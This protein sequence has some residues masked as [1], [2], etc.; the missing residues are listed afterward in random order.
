MVGGSRW[1]VVVG[2]GWLSVEGGCRWWVV[3]GGG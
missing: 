2:G 3:V 1:W